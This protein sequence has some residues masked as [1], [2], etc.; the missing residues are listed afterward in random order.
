[1]LARV[2]DMVNVR[3]VNVYPAA[4]EAVVRRFAEVGGVSLDRLAH[5]AMRELS[6]E[7]ELSWRTATVGVA[8]RWRIRFATRWA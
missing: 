2:D 5:H 1:M 6:V 8:T 7:I 3:G 4:V